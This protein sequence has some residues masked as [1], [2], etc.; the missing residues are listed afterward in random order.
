MRKLAP[1][2]DP[3]RLMFPLGIAFALIGAGLWPAHA[4]RL[5]PYPGALHRSL[6]IQGFETS[7]VVGFL[8]TAMP[9]F[10]HGPRCH[11]VELGLGFALLLGFG[12][13]AMAGA[14][15][16]AQG[17][18]LA[19][20]ALLATAGLRRIAGNPQ[21]PPEEFLF[22]GVGLALG[23]AGGA[24]LLAETRG[25]IPGLPPGFAERLLSL[26][27]VLSLVT[28]VGSLL[29]PTFA[30]LRQPLAIPAVAGPHQRRGRRRLYA[31]AVLGFLGAFA[32][33]VG[34]RPGVGMTLRAL[35][36]TV[37]VAWV[38]KLYRLPRSDVPAFALWGSGWFVPAGL[39]A[40]A[41]FPASAI[42]ALHLTFI[43]GFGML[44]LGVGTR[45]VVA[46]GNHPMAAE[47][48]VL[49]GSI[50][51]L[52]LL[53]LTLRLGAELTPATPLPA[54]A[55]SGLAWLAALGLW[56]FR[57]LGLEAP[58]SPAPNPSRQT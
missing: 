7:F 6:M 48:R 3:Y 37:M 38:W 12:A 30:G 16:L 15:A 17:C 2:V 35:T 52:V 1:S 4:L 49:D 27:M 22:V 33:E 47:R 56:G 51:T 5:A 58:R 57:V 21:K 11:P 8:L 18:F 40:A 50:V 42:A 41:V 28:G 54:L 53:A 13:G 46:H 9:A 31:M 39:W 36:A 32:A 26:E 24:L 43:G 55:S 25:A 14:T 19:T 10:T 20:L 45:V 34:G 23:L 29:V 44:T